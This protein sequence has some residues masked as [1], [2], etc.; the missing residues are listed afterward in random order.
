MDENKVEGTAREW[1]G[2]AQDTVGEF[3]GDTNT[4]IRG[5]ANK[6][7]G[8]AQQN[9]GD[10]ADEARDLGNQLTDTIKDRPVMALMII[11]AAIFGLG[12][13]MRR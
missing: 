9:F 3:V 5:K 1:V 2:K 6:Y 7:V 8:T 13:L 10:M 4:Q 11:G 12:Y